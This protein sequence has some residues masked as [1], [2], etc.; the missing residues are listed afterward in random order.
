MSYEGY[1]TK[2][3]ASRIYD[4]ATHGKATLSTERYDLTKKYFEDIQDELEEMIDSVH[5]L[6]FNE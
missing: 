6:D 4:L 3:V 5:E 2:E 1:T